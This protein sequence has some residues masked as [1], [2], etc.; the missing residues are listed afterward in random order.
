LSNLYFQRQILINDK[1]M[2]FNPR[3][4][5]WEFPSGLD[6]NNMGSGP[7]YDIP[8]LNKTNV[9]APYTPPASFG[10]TPSTTYMQNAMQSP[11]AMGAVSLPSG[12]KS[13]FMQNQYQPSGVTA[14]AAT[15]KAGMS[16]GQT[17]L[18]SAP[19][20]LGL[21]LGIKQ[22]FDSKNVK[23][24]DTISQEDKD[25]LA[26]QKLRAA[27]MRGPG[28]ALGQRQKNIATTNTINAA[29]AGATSGDQVIQ[30]A[31]GAQ[32]NANAFDAQQ[33]AQG[34]ALQQENINK[35]QQLAQYIAQQRKQD[36]INKQQKEAALYEAG[37]SNVMGGVSGLASLAVG[38][39]V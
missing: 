29:A 33:Q 11:S 31:L 34:E 26:E 20:I 15:P 6:Q 5:R 39:P 9:N 8:T 36:L 25:N 10:A 14:P 22:L 3:T 13:A 24:E 19:G 32:Q 2:G 21:G 38:M 7:S 28:Y 37:L 18:A 17:A 35:R 4:G 12:Y 23:L 30:A 16:T 27:S 1:I